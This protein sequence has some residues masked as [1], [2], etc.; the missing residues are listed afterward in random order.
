MEDYVVILDYFPLGYMHEG[1]STFKNKPIAQAIGTEYFTLLEVVP[2][3]GSELEIH[4]KVYI[5]KGKRDKI[6]RVRGKLRFENLT[7]TSRMEIQYAINDIIMEKE[8]VFIK[9]FN[10]NKNVSA[11][12]NQIELLPGVGE[13]RK[14]EI[15]AEIE[16][17]PFKDF[18]DLKKRVP[19][20]GNPVNLITEKILREL[21][22][23]IRKVGKDKYTLF[24]RFSPN[25]KNNKDRKRNPKRKQYRDKR[26]RK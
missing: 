16:K 6:G 5:G 26:E 14:A 19:S 8:E 17:E 3:E 12:F 9:F 1:M 7:A 15:I 4:E 24:T 23:A 25:P 21:N 22:P 11:R 18:D 2:K 13:K 10:E 20:L